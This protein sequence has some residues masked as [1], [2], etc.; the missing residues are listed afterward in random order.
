MFITHKSTFIN[1]LTHGLYK[2]END[3]LFPVIT[4][5]LSL[6][7]E[8][9]FCIP[10]DS[11]HVLLGRNTGDL[12][13]FDGTEYK[14]YQIKDEGYIRQNVLSEG[15]SVSD[16]L[17]AFATL[18]G[19]VLVVGKKSGRIKYTINYINGLPDD[20]IFSLG[21]DNNNGLWMSHQYGLTRADMDLPI[22]NFSIYPGL[23]GNLITSLWHKN[24]LY[25]STSEGVYYLKE[26]KNYS[27]VEI[28]VKQEKLAGPP[29]AEHQIN[30]EPRSRKGFLSLILGK[31]TVSNYNKKAGNEVVDQQVVISPQIR[32]PEPKHFKKVAGKLKSINYVYRKIDGLN[33]KCKQLVAAGDE[34]LASTNKGLFIISNHKA[35]PIVSR[36]YINNISA[37][38]GNNKFFIGTSE[39]YFYITPQKDK[40]SVVYPDKAFNKPVY[41]II[42]TDENTI[43][44]G[45]DDIALRIHLDDTIAGKTDRYTVKSELPERYILE[46]VNDTIF[47]FTASNVRYF[48][49]SLN[50]FSSYERNLLYKNN[51][52]KFILSQPGAPWIKAGDEWMNLNSSSRNDYNDKSLLKIFENLNSVGNDKKNIW[53]I[54]S[55]NMIF[56]IVRNKMPS[57]KPEVGL[58]IKSISDAKG[59]NFNLSDIKFG[60]GDNTVYFDLVAPG[61]VK[62]NSTQY[63]YIVDKVMSEWSKWSYNN[64]I[65]LMI[66]PGRYNL[67]V[68]ARDIWGNVSQPKIVSFTIDAPFTQTTFFYILVFCIVF[69]ILVVFIIAFVR[70]R[71]RQLQKD[72]R[73]LE[74]RVK[75]RTAQ[76]EAQKQEI[77]SSIEYASRIQ[78]AMLPEGHHF[79]K[80][81]SDYFI[82]FNP[83]DIVSGD[84]YWIGEDES[85][86][87]F[88]VADCTGH[89]VPGAFM[90]ALGISILDEIIT[91]NSN[92]KANTILNL[93][94]EKIKT[95]LHQTGK[96]GEANDGLDLALCILHKNRKTIEY[97]GAYNPLIHFHD[98][99]LTEYRAD[100]MPI[101]IY[102]GEKNSFTN[103]EVNVKKGDTLYIFSD[104]YADQ[105]G[106]KKGTKYMKYNLKKLLSEIHS[107]P[108]HEQQKILENEFTSW[109]G[110]ANQID[111]VTILGVKI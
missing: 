46:W 91:N 4:D 43:W 74:T 34:I 59:L 31:K 37:R 67:K 32:L 42:S 89:G 54:S 96:Q 18:D 100:R 81:F 80:L 13:L 76:I 77:T 75:E 56:R 41:S 55:D 3:S 14:D 110:T 21:V 86:I 24:E 26:I 10:Y 93:M 20:E 73:I 98:G 103:Y 62:K 87:F 11:S 60:K 71:E 79:K 90:S 64:T 9:L 85:R 105:F 63:Q 39:G 66:K 70:F 27:E 94:R 29:A 102:Y 51:K 30:E 84:F 48:N 61:Y 78:M 65:P 35:S 50:G 22:D 92:L 8:I 107:R 28:L 69:C 16:S 95:S 82:I 19:G 104:G 5:S 40:W 45:G 97:S 111:D 108:M 2:F 53:V 106:G 12:S 1:I 99:E 47:L 68:R 88:A 101:G 57:I 109:K 36:G 52:L 7:D 6:Y 44:A 33:E 15:L 38:S 49:K 58:F 72:K 83:R 17:Y 25:I 23:K